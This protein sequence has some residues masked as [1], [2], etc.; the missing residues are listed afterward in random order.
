MRGM[1]CEGDALAHEYCFGTD[2]MSDYLY[3]Y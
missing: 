2:E 3:V 1:V